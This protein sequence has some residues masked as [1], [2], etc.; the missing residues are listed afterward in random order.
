MLISQHRAHVRILF[1][2]YMAQLA[3]GEIASQQVLFAEDF[4]LSPAQNA[5]LLA[6]M[7]HFS[8]LGFA[9]RENGKLRWSVT[10]I[11]APL[12]GVSPVEAILTVLDRLEQEGDA[13]PAAFKAPL[14][15]AMARAGAVKSQQTLS[16]ADMDAII[17]DLF[18]CSEP[19][20]TPDGLAVIS[21]LSN[22]DIAR[23]FE[24]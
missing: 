15:L 17:A 21:L 10:A 5:T 1:E 24:I 19:D 4:E 9:L 22:D 3:D 20:Y 2:R 16:Q 14:A 6:N 11:P 18:R 8:D 13:D 7:K 23:R 12:S